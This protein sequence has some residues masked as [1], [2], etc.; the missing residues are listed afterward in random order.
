MRRLCPRA[1]IANRAQFEPVDFNEHHTADLTIHF[2]LVS[3]SG[4][5]FAKLR[6]GVKILSK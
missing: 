1:A 2:V 5:A 3:R 6:E 4:C